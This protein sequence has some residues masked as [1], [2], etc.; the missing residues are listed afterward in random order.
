VRTTK[1]HQLLLQENN[2]LELID[3]PKA[4]KVEKKVEK[5]TEEKA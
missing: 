3:A 4:K 2:H 1:Y 5:K